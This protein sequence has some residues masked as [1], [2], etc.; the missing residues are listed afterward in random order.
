MRPTEEVRMQPGSFAPSRYY[1]AGPILPTASRFGATTIA[2]VVLSIVTLVLAILVAVLPWWHLQ[3]QMDSPFGGDTSIVADF[4]LGTVCATSS[5]GFGG[6]STCAPYSSLLQSGPISQPSTAKPLVDVFGALNVLVLLSLV[7][8]I[9]LLVFVLVGV[10]V[11]KVAYLA[12]I[13]GLAGGTLAV[14]APIYLF[15]GLP[16]AMETM[17]GGL[18]GLSSSGYSG[19]FFGAQSG[20]GVSASW[21]GGSGW[22][23]ALF[24]AGIYVTTAILALSMARKLQPLGTMRLAAPQ[25]SVV[26]LPGPAPYPQPMGSWSPVGRNCVRCGATGITGAPFCPR[27]GAAL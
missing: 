2:A 18:G 5:G 24:L 23:L 10:F 1:S 26:M 17:G 6:F 3:A 21:G 11:P 25:P 8:A 9:L 7:F 20:P 13:F 15:I 4:N 12:G 27:C 22:F 14:L 19:G 16:A